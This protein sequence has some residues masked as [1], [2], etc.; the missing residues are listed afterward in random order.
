MKVL[1]CGG[2]TFTDRY[3]LWAGLTL[4]HQSVDGGITEI[5]EGGAPGADIRAHEWAKHKGVKVTTVQAEWERY[6]RGAGY[7]RNAKMADM[8]PDLVLA[9]PGGK[10]TANMVQIAKARKIK[11]IY[12]EKMPIGKGSPGVPRDPIQIT[13]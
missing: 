12:L 8:K 9:T 13:G 5:I 2:R 4:L 11:V 6:G 7:I 1:V 10:G 3:W